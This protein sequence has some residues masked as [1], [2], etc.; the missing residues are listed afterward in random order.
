[1][2]FYVVL[3]GWRTALSQNSRQLLEDGHFNDSR[4]LYHQCVRCNPQGYKSVITN[5]QLGRQKQVDTELIMFIAC[6]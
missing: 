2:R 4:F 6:K 1:M 5:L 3:L